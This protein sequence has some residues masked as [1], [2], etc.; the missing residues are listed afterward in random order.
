MLSDYFMHT[1]FSNLFRGRI[2]IL[3]KEEIQDGD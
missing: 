3:F 2:I 1:K